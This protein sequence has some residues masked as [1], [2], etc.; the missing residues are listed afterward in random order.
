MHGFSSR[1]NLAAENLGVEGTGPS[2]AT[3]GDELR[4]DEALA[5]RGQVV[6]V[7]VRRVLAHGYLLAEA[8]SG[9]SVAVVMTSS[10]GESHTAGRRG[11]SPA[12]IEFAP[13]G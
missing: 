5:R 6:E 10:R 7:N 4:D 1:H 2:N 8:G 9:L 3:D 13:C 12:G 11:R